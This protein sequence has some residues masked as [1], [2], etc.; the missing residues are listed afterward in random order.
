MFKLVLAVSILA[1]SLQAHGSVTVAKKAAV[2]NLTAS[3]ADEKALACPF[4]PKGTRND[5]KGQLSYSRKNVQKTSNAR[6]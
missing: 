5:K 4:A 3:M 1:G 6:Q 2:P